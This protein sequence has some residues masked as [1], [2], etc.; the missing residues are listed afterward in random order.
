MQCLHAADDT[1]VFE[2]GA[3][4]FEFYKKRT[5]LAQCT[6]S[7][8]RS[9]RTTNFVERGRARGIE[10]SVPLSALSLCKHLNPPLEAIYAEGEGYV[11]LK[12]ELHLPPISDLSARSP[13][14]LARCAAVQGSK[15]II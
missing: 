14:P 9:T 4:D 1:S 2:A 12:C 7:P 10:P 6:A 11:S 13:R 3:C 5:V 8:V 15:L